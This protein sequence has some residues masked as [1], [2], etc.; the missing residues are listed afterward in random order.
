MYEQ[1]GESLNGQKDSMKYLI[2]REGTRRMNSTARI[3]RCTGW[4]SLRSE[5]KRPPGQSNSAEAVAGNAVYADGASA[6][7]AEP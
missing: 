6:E 1:Q 2:I 5:R 7:D 3:S 4:S